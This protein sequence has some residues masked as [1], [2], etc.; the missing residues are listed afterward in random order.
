MAIEGRATLSIG[1]KA[2]ELGAYSW[3]ALATKPA[4]G[5]TL[6]T[7]TASGTMVIRTNR[8]F[9]GRAHEAYQR[10]VAH[11]FFRKVAQGMPF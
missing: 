3:D 2:V 6:G 5:P 10:R 11:R 9:E 4:P 8:R 1:G 7:F